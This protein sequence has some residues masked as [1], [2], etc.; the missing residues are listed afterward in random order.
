MPIETR[1]QVSPAPPDALADVALINAETCAAAGGMS[2]NWWQGQV[3]AGLAPAPA[4]RATRCTRWR[5]SE[6][7][8]FWLGH[9]QQSA[10]KA[11]AGKLL[12]ERARRASEAAQRK[13]KGAQ[14]EAAR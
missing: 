13:R 7:K 14:A 4:I 1:K 9:A 5:L 6:V 10:A 11:D 2:V 12:T 8:A 3:R